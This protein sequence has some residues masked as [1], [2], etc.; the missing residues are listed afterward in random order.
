[1][2][3]V[4]RNELV[5]DTVFT[6][7]KMGSAKI[8]LSTVGLSGIT[9]KKVGKVKVE[10][11]HIYKSFMQAP[12]PGNYVSAVKIHVDNSLISMCT[13]EKVIF[14]ATRFSKVAFDRVYFFM[15]DFTNTIFSECSFSGCVFDRCVFDDDS[16]VDCD[17]YPI[18]QYGHLQKWFMDTATVVVGNVITIG[19]PQFNWGNIKGAGNLKCVD[20]HYLRIIREK[21]IR[22]GALKNTNGSTYSSTG[23]PKTTVPKRKYAS[24]IITAGV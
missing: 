22:K 19:T 14:K 3:A 13:A 18:H 2:T 11:S 9:T 24:R 1:M 4:L 5:K 20:W 8:T 6:S 15:C 10:N 12:V 21:N 17:F 23:Y 16:V 7:K